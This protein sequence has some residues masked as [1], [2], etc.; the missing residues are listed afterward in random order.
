[1]YEFLTQ[2]FERKK[3]LKCK[4]KTVAV[5]VG[6]CYLHFF[7]KQILCDGYLKSR[8][9]FRYAKSAGFETFCQAYGHSHV[10]T[11]YRTLHQNALGLLPIL[12]AACGLTVSSPPVGHRAID[13]KAKAE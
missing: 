8:I 10:Q 13:Q 7:K 4:E 9:V 3:Q 12:Q 2:L 1:V 6:Y 11:H 5:E